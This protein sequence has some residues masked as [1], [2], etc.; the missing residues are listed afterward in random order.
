MREEPRVDRKDLAGCLKRDYGLTAASVAFLPAG[1]D[2]NAGVYRMDLNDGRRFLL[3][4]KSTPLYEAGCLMARYLF[5]RGIEEVVAPVATQSGGLW[6][7]M[8]GWNVTVYNFIKGDTGW[9]GITPAH[10]AEAG[11]IFKQIHGFALPADSFEV[12]REESF[13]PS[14]YAKGIDALQRRMTEPGK[15]STP[16]HAL[17]VAWAEH[18][19]TVDALLS[20]LQK[21]EHELRRRALPHV[22]CHADLHPGNLL[23][24][25]DA[26]VF[27]VD[28]DDV[29][30]APRERDFIF[31]GEPSSGGDA[32]SPFFEG[33]GEVELD[34]EAVTY[35]RCERCVQ[36]LI[37]YSL[38]AFRED[39]SD[40]MKAQSVA[41]FRESV[42][43]RNFQAAQVAARRV[44]VS[45]A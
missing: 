33:Y 12:L 43:G 44:G 28:W 34:W 18:R 22:I 42:T 1:A 24:S 30:L 25:P 10:W 2:M 6:T 7:R 3:K 41:R 37:E 15:A 38:D 11:R 40:A 8:G 31:T 14:V 39:F 17:E 19:G 16:H 9:G 29:M 36:D 35:Y 20:A 32:G 23:R 5:E 13:D 4:I 21:L 26:K 45:L 27:V